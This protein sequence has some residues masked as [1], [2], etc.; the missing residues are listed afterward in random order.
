MKCN[1]ETA[2]TVNNEIQWCTKCGA[3]RGSSFRENMF[4]GPYRS[5]CEWILPDTASQE[6]DKHKNSLEKVEESL[7]DI[8]SESENLDSMAKQLVA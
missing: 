7:K 1:H 4:G 5:W 6:P 8:E 3:F 2:I